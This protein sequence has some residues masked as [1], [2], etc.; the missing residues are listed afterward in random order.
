MW[1]NLDYRKLWIA[2]SLSSLGSQITFLALPITAIGL[3]SASPAQMGLLTAFGTLPYLVLG[4]LVGVWV[5]HLPRRPILM[6]ADLG[7]AGLLLIVP[8]LALLGILRIEHLYFVAFLIGTLSLFYDVTQETYL[9]AI[10]GQEHLVDGNSSIAAV[11]TVAELTAPAV[12]GGFVQLLTAPLAI[13]VDSL[14]FLWSAFW[15]SRIQKKEEQSLLQKRNNLWQEIRAGLNFLLR[16]PFLRPTV[17][18][19]IQWQLF[20][21][22]IDALLILYLVKDLNLPAL[23]IGLVYAVGSLSALIAAR[24]TNRLIKKVGLGTV[25]ILSTLLLGIGWFILP[26]AVGTSW[27]AFSIIAAGM[28]IVGIGNMLW[29]ITIITITQTITPNQLL[30]RV[31]ASKQFL[32]YGALPLGAIIGGWIAEQWGLRTGLFVACLGILLGGIWVW[33][34]SLKS[35]S[36]LP[37]NEPSDEI[38]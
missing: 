28:L 11:E 31:N 2:N 36:S 26:L 14:T 23:A 1:K 8:A 27:T 29:N 3:L 7:R 25:I 17:L 19:G 4:L 24:Y 10:L 22:M 18:T 33:T 12:A 13:T 32:T 38:G 34:S 15:I 5:D 16:N 30:G 20:G 35:L 21:G 9:P 37:T 6:M